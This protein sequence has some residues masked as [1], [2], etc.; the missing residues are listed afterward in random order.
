MTK[1]Q[2]FAEQVLS[3]PG[4]EMDSLAHMAHELSDL[5]RVACHFLSRKNIRSSLLL[6]IV[7]CDRGL[8][9]VNSAYCRSMS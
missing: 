5:R 9:S 4:I 3:F 7:N 8:F 2:A 6:S 1:L